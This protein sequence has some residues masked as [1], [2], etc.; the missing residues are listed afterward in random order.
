M[1]GAE[2]FNV[3]LL[4]TYLTGIFIMLYIGWRDE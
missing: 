3:G 2:M 1:T 4:L